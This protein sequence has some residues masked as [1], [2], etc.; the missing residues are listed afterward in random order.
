MVETLASG[1]AVLRSSKPALIDALSADPDHVLQH[2]DSF[3]LLSLVEYRR[4]KAL[5]DPSEKIR[6][7]LDCIIQKGQGPAEVFLEF[8]K[9]ADTKNTF[10]K[11][12]VILEQVEFPQEQPN[13]KRKSEE[14]VVD[15]SS[16]KQKCEA[17]SGMVTEKQMMLV[18]RGVGRNWKQLGRVAL[19]IPTVR[20]EQIEE[21]NPSNQVERVFAMLRAWRMRERRD[22]TA[23]RLH[24][25]LSADEC[26]PLPESVD[27]LLDPA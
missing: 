14:K 2:A 18:A 3:F 8:L 4:V 11:L 24:A 23:A 9:K 7:L 25:L 22:A 1:A 20:L 13:T 15:I 12:S 17:G 10:P 19:E 27:F 26:A 21:E 16:K 5:T 6:E